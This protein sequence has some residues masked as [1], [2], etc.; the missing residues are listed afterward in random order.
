MPQN[1]PW[2]IFDHSHKKRKEIFPFLMTMIWQDSKCASSEYHQKNTSIKGFDRFY[3]LYYKQGRE[4]KT[5]YY[6]VMGSLFAMKKLIKIWFFY[7]TDKSHWF[8]SWAYYV[9]IMDNTLSQEN[10]KALSPFYHK[11]YFWWKINVRHHMGV[12]HS[13]LT[14]LLKVTLLHGCFSR[15]LNCTNGTKSCSASQI[16]I[17]HFLM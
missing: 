10:K 17:L 8:K 4:L 9:E 14:T 12:L 2:Y 5:Q 7:Q 11:K 3:I 15:F 13:L 16:V 6:G 1:A